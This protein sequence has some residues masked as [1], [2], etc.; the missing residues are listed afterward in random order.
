MA[1][2]LLFLPS[3]EA[4][5]NLYKYEC[6]FL[7]TFLL[8]QYGQFCMEFSGSNMISTVFLLTSEI[9]TIFISCKFSNLLISFICSYLSS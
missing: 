2:I 8:L 7:I 9:L 4:L 5:V 3:T 1:L 6:P